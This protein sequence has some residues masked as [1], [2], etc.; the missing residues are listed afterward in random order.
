MAKPK[1]PVL[2]PNLQVSFYY[3]LQNLRKLYLDEALRAAVEALD[4]SELDDQLA[5]YVSAD[6]L[7]RVASFGL[8]G[9]LF[10][11]VPCMISQNPFLLGYYRLLL[12][13]SQKELYTKRGFGRFRRLEESGEIPDA[14][15]SEIPALCRSLIS[16]AE[17]LVAGVDNLSLE[18]VHDLQ[19]LTIGPQLRGSENTRLGQGASREVFDLL[20]SIVAGYAKEKTTRT[21]LIQNDSGRPVLIEFLSDPDVRITEKLESLV[22]PLVSIEIKGGTDYSNIHNRLGEAEKS[23]QKAKN[24]GFFEFWTIIRVDLPQETARR[25]SPTT[26]HFFHLDRITNPSG[27]EHRQFRSLLG[28]ILGI[29]V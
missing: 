14:L 29:Q 13:F 12:G 16:S 26:S 5:A 18:I 4:L 10:F 7:K 21:I 27:V 11:P 6:R 1:L 2:E 28:S 9:E 8:R 22:R 19:L 3:R 15:K 17:M 24:L 25:E 23:H 20:S